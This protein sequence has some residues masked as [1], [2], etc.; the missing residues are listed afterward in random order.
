MKERR[1]NFDNRALSFIAGYVTNINTDIMRGFT[2]LGTHTF[3]IPA[4]LLLTAWFLFI[5]RRHWYSIKIPAVAL[6]SLLLMFISETNFSPQQAA[7][8]HYYRLQKALVSPA[9]MR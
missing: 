4:N 9:A 7:Q 2:F 8:L 1:E 5:K 3:L 6:S